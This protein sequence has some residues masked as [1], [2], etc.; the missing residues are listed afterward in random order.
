[1]MNLNVKRLSNPLKGICKHN[2]EIM[3]TIDI[4]TDDS[5]GLCP[6]NKGY[7]LRR[8]GRAMEIANC[9]CNY[10]RRVD[11][12]I[13]EFT[14]GNVNIYDEVIDANGGLIILTDT[15]GE[16]KY[17]EIV[18]PNMSDIYKR[19]TINADIYSKYFTKVPLMPTIMETIEADLKSSVLSISPS[20]SYANTDA[21]G[22][23]NPNYDGFLYL[24]RFS[25][26]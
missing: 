14:A 20:M 11:V 7:L 10:V 8:L 2:Q 19:R 13:R 16:I 26:N 3:D 17:V 6:F 23:I 22:K 12:E 1:M 4:V 5:P 24:Y 9:N 15:E 25:A 21:E 18:L